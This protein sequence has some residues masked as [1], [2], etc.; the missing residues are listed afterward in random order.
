[1]CYLLYLTWPSQMALH[2]QA[3][4]PQVALEFRCL[5]VQLLPWVHLSPPALWW[6][7]WV[8]NSSYAGSSC[9]LPHP[10]SIPHKLVHLDRATFPLH[11]PY[12]PI[13]PVIYDGLWRQLHRLGPC[14]QLPRP[15][16]CFLYCNS[17][18]GIVLP[19]LGMF[20]PFYEPMSCITTSSAWIMMCWVP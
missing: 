3:H 9:I 6:N 16:S 7:W 4:Y 17:V 2:Q 19:W 8:I 10:W 1:M 5:C 11:I 13:S 20:L 12:F 18:Y 14:S 15:L